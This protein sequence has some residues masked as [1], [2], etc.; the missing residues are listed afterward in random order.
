MELKEANKIIA[1]SMVAEKS[2]YI[3][4]RENLSSGIKTRLINPWLDT[5][6]YSSS[7]DALVPVW[8][9]HHLFPEFSMNPMNFNWECDIYNC[10]YHLLGWHETDI[11]QEAACIATA[12]VI[13]ELG[14]ECKRK[15]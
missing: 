14:I 15:K 13:K 11:I 9:E 4:G 8:E 2:G 6:Y 12:K 1:L 10:N 3:L 5:N 7:L